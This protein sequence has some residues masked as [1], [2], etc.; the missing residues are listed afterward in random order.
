GG[1]AVTANPTNDVFAI[2]PATAQI[3]TNCTGC[4]ATDHRGNPVHQFTATLNNGKSADVT[5]SVAGGDPNAGAG[6]ITKA[7][8]YSPPGYLT[9]DRAQVMVTAALKADPTAKA[10]SVLT[11]TPG[12]LQP[13]T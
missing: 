7:G 9:S 5:W 4:N 12:F 13:L 6:A 11:L 10:T 3:D 2:A 1:A 8:Q